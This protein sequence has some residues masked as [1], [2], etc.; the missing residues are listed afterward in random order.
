RSRCMR[1]QYWVR[2]HLDLNPYDA[3]HS[4]AAQ[5][6]LKKITAMRDPSHS[7]DRVVVHSSGYCPCTDQLG[8]SSPAATSPAATSEADSSEGKS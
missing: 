7:H 4:K 8:A 1:T 3:G 6:L 5:K 2:M